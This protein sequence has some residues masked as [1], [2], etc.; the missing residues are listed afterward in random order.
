ASRRHL[1][2]STVTSSMPRPQVSVQDLITTVLVSGFFLGSLVQGDSSPSASTAWSAMGFVVAVC[3]T[4]TTV[5]GILYCR[6]QKRAFW[7]G[8]LAFANSTLIIGF[9]FMSER[10]HRPLLV[11]T[12]TLLF[13]YV[14]GMVARSFAR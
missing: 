9:A 2:T 5:L 3:V 12:S 7:T 10:P 1:Q 4:S 14:G 13:G 11:L 6:G 8:M